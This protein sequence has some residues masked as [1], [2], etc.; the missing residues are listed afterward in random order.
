LVK[1]KYSNAE[2]D[3]LFV[4]WDNVLGYNLSKDLI[5]WIDQ[6]G[7]PVV[8]VLSSKFTDNSCELEL[9]QTR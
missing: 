8:K 6:V 3:K 5:G 4:E 1:Y 7:F 9:E 2:K